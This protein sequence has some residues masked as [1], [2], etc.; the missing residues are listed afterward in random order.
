MA[1]QSASESSAAVQQPSIHSESRLTAEAFLQSQDDSPSVERAPLSLATAPRLAS[2]TVDVSSLPTTA[3]PAVIVHSNVLYRP[4][5]II[6]LPEGT[7]A[8]EMSVIGHLRPATFSE[9]RSSPSVAASGAG[10]RSSRTSSIHDYSDDA[11]DREVARRRRLR[12]AGASTQSRG[13]AP[14]AYARETT[15][16]FRFPQVP[17]P[18][19]ASE[20]LPASVSPVTTPLVPSDSTKATSLGEAMP[21]VLTDLPEATPEE[22]NQFVEERVR[23][24]ARRYEEGLLSISTDRKSVV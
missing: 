2:T 8:S 9:R 15:D 22:V 3:A 6:S 19:A 4:S 11:L 7:P 21:V 1:Q 17:T 10:S 16:T 20:Q 18:R 23:L 13:S 5:G 12:A 24:A 14:P